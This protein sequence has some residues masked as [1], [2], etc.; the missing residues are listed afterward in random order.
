[1]SIINCAVIEGV[2][3][4]VTNRVQLSRINIEGSD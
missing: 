1:M 2:V 4:D 3:V